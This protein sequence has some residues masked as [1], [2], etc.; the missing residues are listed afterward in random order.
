MG[1]KRENADNEGD[2]ESDGDEF[3][4]DTDVDDQ[5]YL[6]SMLSKQF[7]TKIDFDTI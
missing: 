7:H 5:K 6:Y 3:D 4:T 1:W 2:G